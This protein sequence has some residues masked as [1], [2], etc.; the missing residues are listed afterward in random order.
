MTE[1][2]AR[3]LFGLETNFSRLELKKLYR[4]K[5]RTAHPDV[6]GSDAEFQALQAA[7]SLLWEL[8]TG[9]AGELRETVD[10]TPLAEL[11]KGYPI[12][13]PAK[14]CEDCNGKGYRELRDPT[15]YVWRECSICKGHKAFAYP[16][17]SCG[18]FGRYKNPRDGSDAGECDR[19]KGTGL[20]FPKARR[21][22]CD[23]TSRVSGKV[24]AHPRVSG[25]YAYQC[26]ACGGYGKANVPSGERL[27]AVKCSMCKG[28]GEIKMWNPV[29]PRGFLGA[30]TEGR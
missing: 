13:V 12:S 18:G 19:C 17:R 10:G 27:Y 6:G 3:K 23:W 30:S 16:C 20:F 24:V 2:E 5:A 4:E 1:I 15:E 28:I 29:L 11:G 25:E 8:G 22:D 14:T 9:E 26:K 21:E 7:F